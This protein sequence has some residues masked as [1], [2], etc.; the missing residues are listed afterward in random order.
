M[1]QGWIVS[2]VDEFRTFQQKLMSGTVVVLF[3]YSVT[4]S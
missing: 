3:K 2:L 4:K 1:N